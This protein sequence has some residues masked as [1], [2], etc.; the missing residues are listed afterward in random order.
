M[1]QRSRF[2]IL[3]FLL[4]AGL[5]ASSATAIPSFEA[6][7][8]S[9]PSTISA[10]PAA[11][12][13]PFFNALEPKASSR[14]AV[15]T[16]A[17]LTL[18]RKTPPRIAP[19]APAL[20]KVEPSVGTGSLSGWGGWIV[21]LRGEVSSPFGYRQHP[22]RRRRMEFHAGID[23]RSKRGTPFRA[24]A[25]G[26][27]IFAGWKRGYGLTIELDHGGGVVTCYAHCS[28][29]NVRLGALVNGGTQIGEVGSTGTTTGNHLHFELR[30][31]NRVFNPGFLFR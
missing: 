23:I 19:G 9:T 25:L 1:H 17:V 20:A 28:R 12:V 16:Y 22:V 31:S 7:K 21:P 30:R 27:V 29:I 14:G 2:R 24:A 11:S 26:R 3:F 6:V 4:C 8:E 15:K 13:A 18:P 5:I 10:A